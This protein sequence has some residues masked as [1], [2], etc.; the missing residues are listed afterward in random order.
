M[1][2]AKFLAIANLRTHFLHLE[3]VFDKADE[4]PSETL[5]NGLSICDFTPNAVPLP[6]PV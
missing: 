5:E 6:C 1:R 3:W 2:S 4:Q